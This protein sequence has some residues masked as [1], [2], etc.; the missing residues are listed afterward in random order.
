MTNYIKV[1]L[2]MLD[3][4]NAWKCKNDK[5]RGIFVC[6]GRGGTVVGGEVHGWGKF[7]WV[8]TFII[9]FPVIKM[10]SFA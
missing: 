5:M 8:N 7:L 1:R 9:G 10:F 4:E 6:L 3:S 2:K